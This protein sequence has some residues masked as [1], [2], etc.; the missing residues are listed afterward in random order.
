MV[1]AVGVSQPPVTCYQSP[2]GKH[3]KIKRIK[4]K[5]PS[6]AAFKI[7]SFCLFSTVYLESLEYVFHYFHC[8]LISLTFDIFIAYF[9][10]CAVQDRQRLKRYLFFSS[11]C[12]K[13][14]PLSFFFSSS[15]I[16]NCASKSGSAKIMFCVLCLTALS[17]V[18]IDFAD[19]LLASVK[20]QGWIGVHGSFL[21]Q[22]VCD[23]CSWMWF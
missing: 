20:Q 13:R 11:L 21:L 8:H 23:K 16:G 18:F 10:C 15:T 19:L 4:M 12:Q 7:V 22:N 5:K 1:N 6:V 17:T 2:C 9:Y 14:F 3:V